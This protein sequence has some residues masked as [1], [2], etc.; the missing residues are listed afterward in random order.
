LALLAALAEDAMNFKIFKLI[1]LHPDRISGATIALLGLLLIYVASPLPVGKLNAPDAGFFPVILSAMLTGLGVVLF[2]NSF[3]SQPFSLEMTPRTLSVVACAAVLLLY[4]LLVNSIG[5][6]ICTVSVLLVLMR[7]YGGLSWRKS[8]LIGVP[9]VLAA[10][11]GFN[12]LGVPLPR[13]I[14][15]WF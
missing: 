13:G 10:Y 1:V 9:A 3:R 2:A 15:G 7:A 6:L 12:E 4:A 5:F 8:L 11:L 14:L